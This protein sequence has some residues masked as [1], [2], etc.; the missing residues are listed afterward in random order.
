[1]RDHL[2]PA[3]QIVYAFRYRD[4]RTKRWILARY[5][6]TQVEIAA[7]YATWEIVGSGE[8][9]Q[10][11]GER[12]FTPFADQ[13]VAPRPRPLGQ[14]LLE[15]GPHRRQ[16][17][18]IDARERQLVGVFLRRLIVYEARKGR[19]DQVR[20]AADLLVDVVGGAG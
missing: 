11:M 5:M 16:R 19:F 7:G 17:P 1:M 14:R 9:R 6:A 18:G 4:P 12:F 13:L 20:N 3:E 8:R 10:P 15:L 2:P